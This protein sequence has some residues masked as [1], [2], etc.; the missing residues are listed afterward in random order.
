MTA[1]ADFVISRPADTSAVMEIV[2][3][4]EDKANALN[5]AAQSQLLN[6]LTSCDNDDTRVVILTG[7]GKRSFCAG[8]DLTEL[9]AAKPVKAPP[10]QDRD[11]WLTIV[12][13]V[14]KHT[15]VVIAAV[16]GYAL[17]GGLSLINA[18]DLAV[19]AESATFGMPE[20]GFGAFPRLAGPSTLRRIQRKRAA[21]LALTGDRIDAQT[22]LNWGLVNQVVADKDL[23]AETRRLATKLA[24]FDAAALRW[25]KRGVDD[26]EPL[27][28]S[29][30][31]E[32]GAYVRDRIRADRAMTAPNTK[33]A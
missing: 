1:E 7:Q 15:A 5:R 30:S 13:S 27:D 12:D 8:V 2:L 16:N 9:R 33:E 6:A 14:R 11:L 23:L 19:S 26:I 25:T 22:A 31:L 10:G 29:H 24:A 3:N 32:F 28:W 21:W 4:R 17:G 20:I 18:S